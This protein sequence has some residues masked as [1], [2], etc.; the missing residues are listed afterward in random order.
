MYWIIQEDGISKEEKLKEKEADEQKP[1]ATAKTK[2]I[3]GVPE[4]ILSQSENEDS[5]SEESSDNDSDAND[6]SE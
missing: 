2:T 6:D 4:D 5:T 1:E 3:G